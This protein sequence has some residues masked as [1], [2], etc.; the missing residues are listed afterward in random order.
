MHIPADIALPADRGI[1]LSEISKQHLLAAELV[2]LGI[3]QH[4]I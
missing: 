4:C 2:L 3:L 1:V